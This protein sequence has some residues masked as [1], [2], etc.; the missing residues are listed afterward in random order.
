MALN[1]LNKLPTLIL[2]DGRAIYDSRVIAE[3]LD[4]LKPEPRL[5][6]V[7][8][9][10][11]LDALRW[12]ALGDGMLDFL[13]MSL[14]ERLRPEQQ[15]SPELLAALALKFRSAFDALEQECP[16]LEKAPFGIGHIAVGAVLGYADFRYENEAW[17]DG[18]PRLTA[19]HRDFAARPSFKATEHAN[20]Y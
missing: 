1:P 19:W 18:R 17:R 14:I 20:V 10:A 5:F 9:S 8:G 15:R 3:Y 16:A 11:R 13:L 2:D 7:A 6:P 12:Q 4:G